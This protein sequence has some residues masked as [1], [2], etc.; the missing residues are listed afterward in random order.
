MSILD[1]IRDLEKQKQQLLAQAKDDALKRA[2]AAIQELEELGFHYQLVER[3][4]P[5]RTTSRRSGVRENIL[6]LLKGSPQGLQRSNI[7]EKLNVKGDKSGERSVSNALTALKKQ[8]AVEHR[9]DGTYT[10]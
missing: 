2:H 10:I 3:R 9:D 1:Q 4:T 7:L 6:K 5:V 8:G